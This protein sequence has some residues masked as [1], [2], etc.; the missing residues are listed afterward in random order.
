MAFVYNATKMTL[1]NAEVIN[2]IFNNKDT[3][4]NNSIALEHLFSNAPIVEIKK[5][6]KWDSIDPKAKTRCRCAY[7]NNNFYFGFEVEKNTHKEPVP[8]NTLNVWGKENG[9]PENCQS[10]IYDDRC[11]VFLWPVVATTNDDDNSES[12]DI[13]LEKQTY[14]AFEINRNGGGLLSLTK[15]HRKFDFNWK[16]KYDGKMVPQCKDSNNNGELYETFLLRI[17]RESVGMMATENNDD[18]E[19][20]VGLHRG[21]ST[22]KPEEIDGEMAWASWV[23]VDDDVVDFH[24]PEM[25]GVLNLLSSEKIL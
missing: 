14:Y 2:Q 10:V 25:F 6:S 9:V 1:E 12:K 4:N 20:R 18:Q 16:G 5:P 13:D 8:S 11:E 23:D 24:R 19:F 21:M 22:R 15:F 3:I 7:D 17:N